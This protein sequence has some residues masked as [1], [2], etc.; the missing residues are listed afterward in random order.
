MFVGEVLRVKKDQS[1]TN[2]SAWGQLCVVEDLNCGGDIQIRI[3]DMFG[4]HYRQ[5]VKKYHLEEP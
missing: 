1:Y 3:Q 2:P 4:C 5:Y